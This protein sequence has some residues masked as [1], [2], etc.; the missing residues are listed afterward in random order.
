MKPSIRFFH[1]CQI[2]LI[3]VIVA[4]HCMFWS[5]EASSST[6]KHFGF[7]IVETSINATVPA[8]TVFVRYQ[9]TIE[10]PMAENLA[11]VWAKLRNHF[12]TV[13]LDLN[14]TG[15]NL[16][17]VS[18]VIDILKEVRRFVLLKTL[19][20][21]GN[22]C[23]SACVPVFLQGEVRIA[24]GAS[25][26]MLHGACRRFTNKPL[27]EPTMRYIRMLRSAGVSE[28]FVSLL[29]SKLGA[30]E[31]GK[32]WLSGYELV[33]IHKAGVI[34]RLTDAWQPEPP[35]VL[36]FDPQIRSR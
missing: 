15:G 6:T 18:S 5:V 27:A 23:L 24:G 20:R 21:N 31:P 25:V 29:V 32:L 36:A 33:H 22:Q 28:P 35:K 7:D 4:L 13:V 19:V 26:W 8:G 14:S 11:E 34:M 17:H 1:E 2:P 9:G 16:S 12:S 3:P 10:Y 30:A